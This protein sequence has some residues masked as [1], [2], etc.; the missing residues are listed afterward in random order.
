MTGTATYVDGDVPADPHRRRR[1]AISAVAPPPLR[2]DSTRFRVGTTSQEHL[3]LA[4]ALAVLRERGITPPAGLCTRDVAAA[5]ATGT[6]VCFDP[7]DAGGGG[8]DDDDGDGGGGDDDDDDGSEGVGGG[9]EKGMFIFYGFGWDMRLDAFKVY[10]MFHGLRTVPEDLRRG[11]GM[12][13]RL[14]WWRRI[15]VCV[16]ACVRYSN[17]LCVSTAWASTVRACVLVCVRA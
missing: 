7:A 5:A 1:N 8:D 11:A 13:V 10:Y 12:T 3:L 16:R 14:Y 4:P 17:V 15:R 2:V 9:D 6:R